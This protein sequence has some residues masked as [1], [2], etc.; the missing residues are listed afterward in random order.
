MTGNAAQAKLV[1]LQQE[2]AASLLSIIH[3]QQTRNAKAD[4]AVLLLNLEDYANAAEQL[5]TAEQERHAILQQG[6]AEQQQAGQHTAQPAHKTVNALPMYA[7]KQQ[8]G[9]HAAAALL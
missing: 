7:D 9:F 2:Y 3:A 5:P 4:S 6:N 8:W 1:L